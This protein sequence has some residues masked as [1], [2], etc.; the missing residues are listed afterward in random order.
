MR[1]RSAR[2]DG[3]ASAS[4]SIATICSSNGGAAMLKGVHSPFGLLCETVETS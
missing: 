2:S 4:S 1:L 3:S